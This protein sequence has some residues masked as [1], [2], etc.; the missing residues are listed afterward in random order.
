M[1]ETRYSI[2][3]Q[4]DSPIG[5]CTTDLDAQEVLSFLSQTDAYLYSVGEYDEDEE[6]V[7]RLNGQ[8]WLD[9]NTEMRRVLK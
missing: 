9:Q 8:E 2:S 6:C 4:D 3:S 5:V 1:E 7:E